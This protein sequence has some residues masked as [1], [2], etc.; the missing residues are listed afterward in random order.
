MLIVKFLSASW[1]VLNES[2]LNA[3]CYKAE[4][5]NHEIDCLFSKQVLSGFQSPVSPVSSSSFHY[6][7]LNTSAVV[8]TNNIMNYISNAVLV[9]NPLMDKSLGFFRCGGNALR[10]GSLPEFSSWGSCN[11]LVEMGYWSA[12]LVCGFSPF[13]KWDK[14]V[15]WTLCFA[16]YVL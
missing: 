7:H 4:M 12:Y 1:R 13:A 9:F 10:G 5:Y 16:F 15:L 11:C 8:N 6:I 14:K 2:L 3:L